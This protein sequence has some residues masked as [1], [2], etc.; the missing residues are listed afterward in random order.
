MTRLRRETA[1]DIRA[2]APEMETIHTAKGRKPSSEAMV[3]SPRT[4][5]R[6]RKAAPASEER[7]LGRMTRNSTYGQPAPQLRA[8][9]TRVGTSTARSP[10]SRERYTNGRA[11]TVYARTRTKGKLSFCTARKVW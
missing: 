3:N 4:R 1:T 10:A 2:W 8:A 5:A 9:S 11:M 6:V 7:R